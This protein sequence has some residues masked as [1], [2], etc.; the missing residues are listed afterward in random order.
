MHAASAAEAR[1]AVDERSPDNGDRRTQS[2]PP[3]SRWRALRDLARGAVAPQRLIYALK[4]TAT[5]AAAAMLGHLS[6]GSGQWASIAVQIVGTRDVLF[7]GGSFRI[8]VARIGGTAAGALFAVMVLAIAERAARDEGAPR[9]SVAPLLGP[10]AVWT[11]A[12]G[13]IRYTPALAYGA[14]VASYTPHI[15]LFDPQSAA[16]DWRAFA[17]RR[18]EQNLLGLALFSAVELGVLPQR[19]S[20]LLSAALAGALRHAATATGAVWASALH[21]G[22]L[23]SSCAVSTMGVA[24]AAVARV[25]ADLT[26]Q[27]ALLGEASSEPMAPTHLDSW[28]RLVDTHV[29]QLCTLLALMAHCADAGAA[30]AALRSLEEPVRPA[31][32]ALRE[33]LCALLGA[34]ADEVDV[35][36]TGKS[37]A[38]GAAVD[39][40]LEEMEAQYGAAIV[41]VRVLQ[42]MASAAAAATGEAPAPI[43]SSD[44]ILSLHALILCT[45]K[46][47]ATS[48]AV[49]RCV[50]E[51]LP[52]PQSWAVGDDDGSFKT[53]DSGSQEGA[54][55][56]SSSAGAAAACAAL[57]AQPKAATEEH[58]C[59]C[60]G[61]ACAEVARA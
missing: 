22:A 29:A 36:I 25:R 18:I 13:A 54:T 34:I 53:E 24:N 51:M 10:I 47:V 40:A 58:R 59:V 6:C 15:I 35:G 3:A 46:L 43:F 4:M 50:R 28:H 39:V 48:H 49:R 11:A 41:R 55:L 52:P 27:R 14:M 31:L 26:R 16:A 44:A 21:D 5:V 32:R 60:C 1:A 9:H 12:C 8:A 33:R 45:R 19:A 37:A 30:D 38:P 7:V 61:G 42:G 2:A 17:Y 23:C 56:L 57:P 20:T